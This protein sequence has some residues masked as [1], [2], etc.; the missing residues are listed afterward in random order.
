MP[1]A[2]TTHPTAAWHDACSVRLHLTVLWLPALCTSD[3][4]AL[5]V[6]TCVRLIAATLYAF[7]TDVIL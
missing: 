1:T 5:H 4:D 7:A 3:D 2:M 6:H